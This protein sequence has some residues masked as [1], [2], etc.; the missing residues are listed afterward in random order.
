MYDEHRCLIKKDLKKGLVE[1]KNI[2]K[3]E[4]DFWEKADMDVCMVNGKI[5][6]LCLKFHHCASARITK[7]KD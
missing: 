1:E 5:S 6:L 4:V 2:L 7:I 3:R